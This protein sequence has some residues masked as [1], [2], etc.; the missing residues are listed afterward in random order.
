MNYLRFIFGMIFIVFLVGV[1]YIKN[2]PSSYRVERA[3]YTSIPAPTL[4]NYIHDFE[5]WPEWNPWILEDPEMK[6][7]FTKSNSNLPSYEWKGRDGNGSMNT[8]KTAAPHLIEQEMTFEGFAPSRV[9]WKIKQKSDSLH[10]IMESKMGFIMKAFSVFSGSMDSMIGPFYE[11][12]LNQINSILSDQL[13]EHRYKTIGKV[14]LPKQ[15]YVSLT[16]EY[17]ETTFD[18][19]LIAGSKELA[20]FAESKNLNKTGSIFT[21]HQKSDFKNNSWS[22]GL[23]IEKYFK[24]DHPIIKCRF[25]KERPALKGVHLGWHK[26]IEKSWEIMNEEIK[27]LNPRLQYYPRTIY[28]VD[29][30]SNADPL[31]WETELFLPYQ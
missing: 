9:V 12:G 16:Y 10:W 8:L 11:K 23:P 2:Q 31:S 19:L 24:T 13:N 20:E 22:L 5:N 1:L 28:K 27:L 26:N 7:K 4:Y 21:I 3:I 18:S 30:K 29:R 14:V 17:D 6:L 15:F 25:S